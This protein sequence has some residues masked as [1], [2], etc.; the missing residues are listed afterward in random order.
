MSHHHHFN[1]KKKLTVED[2][3]YAVNTKVSTTVMGVN[4]Q[5]PYGK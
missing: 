1:P 2:K 3:G 5:S 4:N